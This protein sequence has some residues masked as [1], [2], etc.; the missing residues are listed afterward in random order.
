MVFD[1]FFLT[2]LLMIV[3]SNIIT[4]KARKNDGENQETKTKQIEKQKNEI[5]PKGNTR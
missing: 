3:T 4:F 5:K 1:I 2:W